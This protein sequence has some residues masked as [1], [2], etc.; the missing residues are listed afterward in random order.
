MD[1]MSL[2]A[3]QTNLF[4]CDGRVAVLPAGMDDRLCAVQLPWSGGARHDAG[5]RF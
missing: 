1:E 3:L 4:C 5:S 2:A